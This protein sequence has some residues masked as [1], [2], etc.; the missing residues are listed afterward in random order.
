MAKKA[1]TPQEGIFIFKNS[2]GYGFR[3]KS[4]RFVLVTA[5]GYNSK[6]SAL[7]GLIA[8]FNML[9]SWVYDEGTTAFTDL[10]KKK[11]SPKK[12]R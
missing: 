10:T 9:K 8:T 5:Q 1:A 12:K 3:V 11:V 7:K 2:K 4:N 6:P